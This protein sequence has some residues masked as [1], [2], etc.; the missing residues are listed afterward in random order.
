MIALIST[1]LSLFSF[2]LL[3]RALLSWVPNKT[4]AL[5]SI[6]EFVVAVTEPVLAPVRRRLPPMQGFDLSFLVVI[7]G[8][9]IVRAV[10]LN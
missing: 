1:L 5:A 6:N 4:G 3:A 7:V 10:F 8:I 2:T 9:M